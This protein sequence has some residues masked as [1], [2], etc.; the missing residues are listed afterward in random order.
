VA[1]LVDFIR[2][3]GRG[4]ILRRPSRRAEEI[5]ADE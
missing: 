4:V 3:S 2:T 1:Y 5:V